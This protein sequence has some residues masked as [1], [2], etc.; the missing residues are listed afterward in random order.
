M[1]VIYTAATPM[2]AEILRAYLGAHGI[3]ARVLG[4]DL[5]SARGEL[6]VDA[7]PRLW[8]EDPR[9]TSRA[10]ALLQEYR[11]QPA[12]GPEWRC[13]CGESVPPDFDRCWSCGQER[14]H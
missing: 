12:A 2:E 8:L 1:S 11:H 7:Y 9:D 13:G 4:T 3:A 14:A 5:W 6:A 10:Q